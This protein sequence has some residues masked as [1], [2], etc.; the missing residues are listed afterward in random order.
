MSLRQKL[1]RG[2]LTGLTALVIGYSG[3]NCGNKNDEAVQCKVDSDCNAGYKCVN[4]VCEEIPVENKSPI[5]NAGSDQPLNFDK[6]CFDTG[7]YDSNGNCL[8]G[9]GYNIENNIHPGNKVTLDGSLSSDPEGKSLQYLWRQISGPNATLSSNSAVNPYFT[10]SSAGDYVFGLEVSDGV[11]TSNEDSVNVGIRNNLAPVA[12]A[13]NDKITSIGIPVLFDGS[14]SYDKDG[15]GGILSGLQRCSWDFDDGTSYTETTS[16]ALDG[17][18]DCKVNHTYNT[19]KGFPG[20][21]VTL[22][23]EDDDKSISTDTC[24]V[25]VY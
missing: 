17:N 24:Q 8:T 3:L 11:K 4:N 16:N 9:S 18:F 13:G 10:P 23:I 5:A 12:D 25:E 14:A 6:T 20:Y 1:V 7:N 15:K 2:I 21:T 22:E 19:T